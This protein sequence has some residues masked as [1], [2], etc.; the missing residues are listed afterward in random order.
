MLL[1]FV[2]ELVNEKVTNHWSNNGIDKM[3]QFLIRLLPKGNLVPKSTYEAKK[4]LC[5]FGL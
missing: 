4:T 5:D 3:L 1:K 2:S